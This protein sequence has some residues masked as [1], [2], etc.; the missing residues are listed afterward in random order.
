MIRDGVGSA[1]YWTG[2]V[3]SVAIRHRATRRLTQRAESVRA[4]D[5]SPMRRAP[6]R[7]CVTFGQILWTLA[8]AAAVVRTFSSALEFAEYRIFP[9]WRATGAVGFVASLFVLWRAHRDLGHHW[10]HRLAIH[11]E[12]QLVTTGIYR[13]VRHPLYAA[14]WLWSLSLVLLLPNWLIGPVSIVGFA[15]V[16]YGRV[17]REER[18]L[19]DQFGAAYEQYSR[20]TNRLV[21]R[22]CHKRS[23]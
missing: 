17:D 6:D 19:K 10:D 8:Q 16:Y 23:E 11:G 13:Y 14:Y 3:G 4:V 9:L 5:D 12:H 21:P 2:L 7:P 22:M 18:L 1:I 20:Q 15:L